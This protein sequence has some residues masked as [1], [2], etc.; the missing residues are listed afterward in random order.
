MLS[1]P[2]PGNNNVFKP[3]LIGS[4]LI[5]TE[6]VYG[7]KV[8]YDFQLKVLL[9]KGICLL[10][11]DWYFQCSVVVQCGISGHVSGSSN[12][13]IPQTVLEKSTTHIHTESL[14]LVFHT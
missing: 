10:E 8:E 11:I 4:V 2:H 13:A 5:G 9:Y 7:V 3:L 14:L 1:L 12:E 6:V